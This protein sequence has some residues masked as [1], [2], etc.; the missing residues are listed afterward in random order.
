MRR[1][2]KKKFFLID[3]TPGEIL[4]LCKNFVKSNFQNIQE[5]MNY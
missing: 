1:F 5:K 4:N 2:D 3:N